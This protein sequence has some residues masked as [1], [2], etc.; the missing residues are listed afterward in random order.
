M[1]S[2]VFSGVPHDGTLHVLPKYLSAYQTAD[3][4]KEFTNIVA[5]LTEPFK[6]GDVNGDGE[7][8]ATDSACLVNVLAGLED[9]DE[10]EGRA[11][12]TG[13]GGAV[14]SADIAAIVNILA[15][16]EH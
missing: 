10:Y 11:D 7:V 8:G 16:L 15:G 6:K 5:D 12:V 4:W 13:D 1:G 9:A 14:T 3:Q 2:D